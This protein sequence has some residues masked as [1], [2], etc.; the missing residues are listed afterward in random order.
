MF[1]NHTPVEK[2]AEIFNQLALMP[3]TDGAHYIETPWYDFPVE[4]IPFDKYQVNQDISTMFQMLAQGVPKENIIAWH[5]DPKQRDIL[6][7]WLPEENV[8]KV[9]QNRPEFHDVGNVAFTISDEMFPT[10]NYD[11]PV[12]MIASAH[13]AVA[14]PFRAPAWTKRQKIKKMLEDNGLKKVVQ[15]PHKYFRQLDENGKMV[16]AKVQSACYITEPGYTGD[17]QVIDIA[18]DKTFMAPRGGIYPK[19]EISLKFYTG[20]RHK[21]DK[22][23]DVNGDEVDGAGK[24][25]TYN[26][27][28]IAITTQNTSTEHD[29][30]VLDPKHSIPIMAKTAVWYKPG[31]V[32]PSGRTCYEVSAKRAPKLIKAMHSDE[33][34]NALQGVIVSKNWSSEMVRMLD[35]GV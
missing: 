17:V 15:I 7:A 20:Q 19:A 13:Y 32:V 29:P 10:F 12:A 24:S 34:A 35:V 28:V 25:T 26:C 1:V 33:Y 9:R 6:E 8:Y 21:W 14:P 31:D 2:T 22:A 27:N 3:K 5:D 4:I 11:S 23:K 30:S 18:R 16:L